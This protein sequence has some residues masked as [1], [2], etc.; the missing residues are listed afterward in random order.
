MCV[1]ILKCFLCVIYRIVCICNHTNICHVHMCSLYMCMFFTC[2]R[3]WN[4]GVFLSGV[5]PHHLAMIGSFLLYGNPTW[6][7]HTSY[8]KQSIFGS[9]IHCISKPQIAPIKALVWH[10]HTKAQLCDLIWLVSLLG[11]SFSF[12]NTPQSSPVCTQLAGFIAWYGFVNT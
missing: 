5:N 6:L 7:N 12:S 8:G 3:N 11:Y 1:P 10:A 9:G 2:Q 4:D